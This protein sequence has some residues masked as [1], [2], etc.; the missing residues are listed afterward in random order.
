MS[1][2]TPACARPDLFKYLVIILMTLISIAAAALTFL[3][4]YASLRSED[5][6]QS[7]EFTAVNSTGLFFN[8][9]LEAAHG[10][11][12]QERRADYV[13]RAVRAD[14]KARA[15]RLNGDPAAA[16]DYDLDAERWLAAAAEVVASHPLFSDFDED[17]D[18][19]RESLSRE[20]YVDAERQQA[21]LAQS[22]T[23]SAK[24]NSYVAILSTLSVALFLGGLS[25]TLSAR[26]RYVLAASASGLA[27]ICALWTLATLLGPVPRVPDEAIE[28]F[29]SGEIKYNVSVAHGGSG[30]EAIADFDAALERAPRYQRVYFYRSLAN[31]DFALVGKHLDTAQAIADGEQAL[32]LGAATS[33]MYGNLG[34]LYYLNGQYNTALSNT[35][36]ALAYTSD[37]CYLHF[38]HGL[39]LAALER[40]AESDAAYDRAIECALSKSSQDDVNYYLDVG[41]IDLSDLAAARP[42]LAPALEPRIQR[43]KEALAALRMFGEPRPRDTDARFGEITFGLEVVEQPVT[44]VVEAASEFPQSATLVYAVLEYENMPADARWMTRWLHDGFENSTAVYESWD[45]GESGTVWVNLFNGG[46]LTTGNYELDVFVEGRLAASGKMTVQSGPLPT[47]APYSSVDLA[48]TINYPEAWKVTEVID[49]EVAMVAARNPDPEHPTF[50]G[51]T[52]FVPQSISD[53][54]V[55]PIFN[56]YFASLEQAFT[57]FQS[58]ELVAVT[59]AGQP[60]QQMYYQYRDAH[61]DLI[62]GDVAGVVDPNG[63]AVFIVVLETKSDDWN[64]QIDLFNLMLERMQ[65]DTGGSGRAPGGPLRQ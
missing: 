30:A 55:V 60:A 6:V 61:G 9:G 50:F 54:A 38:N 4:T 12:V 47:M 62:F 44:Q 25:L 29:V 18:L 8:A 3:Q 13:Q 48:V 56:Q 26:V 49:G 53:E 35:E 33:P 59:V 24:A 39:T 51:V 28:R 57:D 23:W 5:L 32:K 31:T 52:S 36:K 1:V 65:I 46:G 22:Q 37:E 42:D 16:G 41:V 7:S 34:W 10:A 11:D 64:P 45:Y 40:A 58:E 20:A 17:Q 21:L 27:F 14:T 15:L 63:Q 2:E 43:L 19:Y